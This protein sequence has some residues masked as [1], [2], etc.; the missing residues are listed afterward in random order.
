MREKGLKALERAA[1]AP[2]E[3]AAEERARA[4]AVLAAAKP[5]PKIEPPAPLPVTGSNAVVR[6]DDAAKARDADDDDGE[7]LG[8]N[9]AETKKKP[10]QNRIGLVLAGLVAAAFLIVFATQSGGIFSSSGSGETT[11]KPAPVKPTPPASN[12]VEEP[13]P[14]EKPAI[15]ATSAPAPV[16]TA[17]ATATATAAE[18]APTASVTAT[19]TAAPTASATARPKTTAA[20]ADAK[21]AAPAPKPAKPKPPANSDPY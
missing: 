15:T 13:P 1:A 2:E 20:P 11:D 8:K 14:V 12:A 6:P 17:T 9:K 7:D 4:A 10:S 21:T 5:K 3:R 18:P 16:V 19:A